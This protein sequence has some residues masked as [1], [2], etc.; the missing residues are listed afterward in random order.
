MSQKAINCNKCGQEIHFDDGLKSNSGKKIPLQGKEGYDKHDCPNNPYKKA[1]KA[2]VDVANS[3]PNSS[4]TDK[5][6]LKRIEDRVEETYQ[7]LQ[8]TLK[9][10]G[11]FETGDAR[12]VGAA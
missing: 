6:Q 9:K 1:E 7:L 2:F 4:L 12:P 8:A 5:N 11:L 10:L 3:A